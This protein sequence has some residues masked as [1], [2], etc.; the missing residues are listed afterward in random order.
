M[1]AITVET[2]WKNTDLR[3]D[4]TAH[5]AGLGFGELSFEDLREDRTIYAASSGWV[6]TLTIECGTLVCAC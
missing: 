2:T 6:C 3:E 4:L 1:S 5:P